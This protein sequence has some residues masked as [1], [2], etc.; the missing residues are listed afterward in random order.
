[1]VLSWVQKGFI[2]NRWLQDSSYIREILWEICNR[3][4]LA[5]QDW[6]L[7]ITKID[8]SLTKMKLFWSC[9][10]TLDSMRV[11]LSDWDWVR[12]FWRKKLRACK[13]SCPWCR[14]H[15]QP[16]LKENMGKCQ[17]SYF[18]I[19]LLASWQVDHYQLLRSWKEKGLNKKVKMRFQKFS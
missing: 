16:L 4:Y 9:F 15:I 3:I 14:K 6:F 5:A 11:N 2:G 13:Y 19:I 12:S 8:F 18:C 17:Q 10:I 7:I 1:M